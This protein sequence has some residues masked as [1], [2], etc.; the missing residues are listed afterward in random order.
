M[1]EN[2]LSLSESLAEADKTEKPERDHFSDGSSRSRAKRNLGV[3][4]LASR[5]AANTRRAAQKMK[6]EMPKLP[7]PEEPVFSADDV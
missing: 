6:D 5:F 4:I 1:L 3:T 7:K 2:S